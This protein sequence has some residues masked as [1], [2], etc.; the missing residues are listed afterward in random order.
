MDTDKNEGE[1][2]SIVLFSGTVDKILAATTLTSGAAAMGKKVTLFLTFW[3]LMA[4]R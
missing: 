4:F 2:F 1:R 3:G